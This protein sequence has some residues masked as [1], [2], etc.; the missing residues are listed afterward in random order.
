MDTAMKAVCPPTL[1][2]SRQGRV[3]FICSPRGMLGLAATAQHQADSCT[4]LVITDQALQT[5]QSQNRL[6][7]GVTQ[8]QLLPFSS[9]GSKSWLCRVSCSLC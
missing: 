4:A 2:Q 5:L 9:L 3:G 7:N 8:A 6:R 1:H